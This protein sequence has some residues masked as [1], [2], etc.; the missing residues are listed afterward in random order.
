MDF[1]EVLS[2]GCFLLDLQSATKEGVIREMVGA[3]AAAGKLPDPQAAAAA[4]LE[5]E[6]QMST[7]MQFGIAI[8][9]G[10]VAGMKSLAVAL[11]IKKE[12]VD[13]ASLDGQPCR[14]FVMT[15][16]PTTRTGPHVQYLAEIGKLLRRPSIRNRVLRATSREE[17]VGILT[18]D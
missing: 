3:L 1:Q 18:C 5:R 12:G 13:F 7:G 17:I 10:K 8:P 15:L 4:V 6:S 2:N 16:S 9:H 11:G 14:I